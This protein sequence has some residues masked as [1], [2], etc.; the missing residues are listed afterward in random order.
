LV[1]HANLVRQ[2]LLRG[3]AALM[4]ALLLCWLLV[5]F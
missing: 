4:L 1:L 2:A 3:L 5:S